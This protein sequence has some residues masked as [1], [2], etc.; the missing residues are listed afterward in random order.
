MHII[1]VP[2]PIKIL[3]PNIL[4][5]AIDSAQSQAVLWIR[6]WINIECVPVLRDFADPDPYSQHL[7][8]SLRN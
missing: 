3:R 7:Y 6:L 5:V 8:G 1:P 2:V 4:S